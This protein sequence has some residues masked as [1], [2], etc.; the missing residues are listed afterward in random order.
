MFIDIPS[1]AEI[2]RILGECILILSLP[3]KALRMLVDIVRLARYRE[4]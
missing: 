4:Y 2:L 3:G 1:L